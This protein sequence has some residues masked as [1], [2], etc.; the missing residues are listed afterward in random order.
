LSASSDVRRAC[1][2]AFEAFAARAAE[3]R[4]CVLG[5]RALQRVKFTV[6]RFLV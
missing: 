3:L 6:V 1:A 4:R 2:A 5:S